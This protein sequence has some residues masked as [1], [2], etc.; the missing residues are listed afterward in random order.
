MPALTEAECT[1][2][3]RG[4]KKCIAETKIGNKRYKSGEGNVAAGFQV[5]C[6][7]KVRATLSGRFPRLH[8]ATCRFSSFFFSPLQAE[9]T[10]GRSLTSGVT[11]VS[12]V[13]LSAS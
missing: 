7:Q 11:G 9:E 4:W 10:P 2:T 6:R 8:S 12:Y 3:F 13:K 5:V 1:A